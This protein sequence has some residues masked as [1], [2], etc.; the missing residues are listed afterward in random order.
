MSIYGTTLRRSSRVKPH[1]PHGVPDSAPGNFDATANPVIA[2]HFF[3]VEPFREIGDVAGRIVQ[4]L[5]LAREV[6][7]AP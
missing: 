6:R 4:R 7:H 5:V 1:K 2:R 3:G